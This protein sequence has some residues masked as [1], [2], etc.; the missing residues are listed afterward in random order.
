[1]DFSDKKKH[2]FLALVFSSMVSLLSQTYTETLF[3]INVKL[4]LLHILQPKS[5]K[6]YIK[7][8]YIDRTLY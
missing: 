7:L 3:H 8:Q 4:K 1:M 2:G 6:S 5:D